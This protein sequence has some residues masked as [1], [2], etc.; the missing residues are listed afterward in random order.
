MTERDKTVRLLARVRGCALQGVYIP[1]DVSE[2][3]HLLE[4]T[5]NHAASADPGDHCGRCCVVGK[6][7]FPV[8]RRLVRF[9]DGKSY[10][11]TFCEEHRQ[12]DPAQE[13]AAHRIEIAYDAGAAAERAAK[14][15]VWVV[16]RDY[17]TSAG[18]DDSEDV[19]LFWSQ[20]GAE[21]FREEYL[22]AHEYERPDRVSVYRAQVKP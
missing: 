5:M 10:W 19:G 22:V 15:E 18:G 11:F 6:K 2:L 21:K 7:S 16:T 9:L 3:C 20:A 12:Y 1:S 13:D 4:A 17:E 14:P 8:G